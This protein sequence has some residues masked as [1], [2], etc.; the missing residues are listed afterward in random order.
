MGCVSDSLQFLKDIGSQSIEKKADNNGEFSLSL[1]GIAKTADTT[2]IKAAIQRS[3]KLIDYDFPPNIENVVIKPNLCY[4][5][6]YSTGLTT[7]PR[8]VAALITLIRE[9]SKGARISVV[10]SDAS[11]MRCKYAFKMLGYEKLAETCNVDLVNL[12]E[13]EASK[14][15]VTVRDRLYR[16][17]L[18]SLIQDADLTIN[19]P[20]IKYTFEQIKL[21]CALKNI[22]GCNPYQKKFRYHSRIEDV[23]VALNKVMQF[24]LCIVD[25]YIVSGSQPNRI[26]LVMSSRDPVAIDAAAAKIAGVNRRKVKYIALAEREGLGKTHFI[27]RGFPLSYFENRYPRETVRARLISKG[28]PFAVK[29]GLGRRLGLG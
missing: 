5:W 7:D 29:L 6:D 14:V 10:E 18:P 12:S 28:A 9:V 25:G 11:A 3:L 17:L 23:I 8:F 1:I 27:S 22:F 2:G 13:V 4:Y 15:E 24:D 26:G 16:F 21:T 20:K 19:V